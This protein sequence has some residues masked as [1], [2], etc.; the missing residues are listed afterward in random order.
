[1]TLGVTQK[2]SKILLVR[3]PVQTQ[4]KILKSEVFFIGIYLACVI[5]LTIF[6]IEFIAFLNEHPVLNLW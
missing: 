4:R 5:S 6:R 2:I 3:S 1:L